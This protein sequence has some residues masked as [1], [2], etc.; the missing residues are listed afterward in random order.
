MVEIITSFLRSLERPLILLLLSHRPRYGYELIREFKK[1]TG[2]K[3]KP[4]FIYPFL[5]R[6]EKQG[7]IISQYVQKRKRKVRIYVLTE[8]GKKL[9]QRVQKIFRS[10][11]KELIEYLIKKT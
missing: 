7:Y 1:L 8:K 11:I 2:R 10:S 6:L 3:L 9:L 5:H 4:G